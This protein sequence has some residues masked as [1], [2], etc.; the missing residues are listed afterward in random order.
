[1]KH[2]HSTSPSHLCAHKTFA[3]QPPLQTRVHTQKGAQAL[4]ELRTWRGVRV[5]VKMYKLLPAKVDRQAEPPVDAQKVQPAVDE[6]PHEERD[7]TLEQEEREQLEA[8]WRE[9]E[10]SAPRVPRG[11]LEVSG[12]EVRIN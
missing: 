1:M 2:L 4:V 11:A 7:E 9:F 12:I 10:D 3:L 6:L 5:A 8:A